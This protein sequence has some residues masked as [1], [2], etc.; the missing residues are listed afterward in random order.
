MSDD[1][2]VEVLML[3]PEGKLLAHN[4][5]EDY[6]DPV[7]LKHAKEDPRPHRR[8]EGRDPFQ[9]RSRAARRSRSVSNLSPVRQQGAHGES[10]VGFFRR[11]L[12]PG[13]GRP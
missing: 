4:G 8:V 7:R 3:S 6:F 10:P 11:Y 13:A 2:S 1:S 5:A 9:Q 12:K